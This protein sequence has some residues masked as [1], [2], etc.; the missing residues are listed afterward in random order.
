MIHALLHHSANPNNKYIVRYTRYIDRCI[1][2]AQ[3]TGYT[4]KHHIIPKSF[5]G[6]NRHENRIVLSASQHFGAHILLAK[7][8]GSPKMIKALHKMMYSRTGDV[9]RDYNISAKLYEYLKAEHS[10]I[11]SAYSKD[12]VTARHIYTGEIK[13]IPK[14]LFEYYNGVLYEAVSKGRKD[15]PEQLV[16]KSEMAKR[17]RNVRKGLRSRELA[18]TKYLYVTPKGTCETRKDML[19]LYPEL[20]NSF[21]ELLGNDRYLIT[22]K[23][24]T[25][26]PIF[27]GYVGQS[28]ENAGFKRIQKNDNN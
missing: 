11:V 1:R 6:S 3:A 9:K 28:L 23:F 17:P 15:S 19:L 18:A 24:A 8:T 20:T 5:G 21:V 22:K 25:M 12:T 14:Q 7:A 26:Y 13:R 27:N 2:L 4:E 10:K 16:R